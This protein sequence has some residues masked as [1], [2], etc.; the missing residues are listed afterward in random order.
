MRRLIRWVIVTAV[1]QCVVLLFLA[2]VLPGFS[3]GETQTALLSAVVI[4]I[5]LALA[6]PVINFIAG[7]FHPILF[8]ILTF[9]L[10]RISPSTS[11]ARSMS[12]G[13]GSIASGPASWSAW[14]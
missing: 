14:A 2:W 12:R 7:R 9:G 4:S 8:P 6:W 5:V 10:S 11:S 1:V 13:F 3:L